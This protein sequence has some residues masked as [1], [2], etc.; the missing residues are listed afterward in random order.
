MTWILLSIALLTY[1]QDVNMQIA[2]SKDTL[3][4]NDV[5]GMETDFITPDGFLVDLG[6]AKDVELRNFQ[7]NQWDQGESSGPIQGF[8]PG[9]SNLGLTTGKTEEDRWWLSQNDVRREQI[10]DYE[11]SR[12]NRKSINM[13]KQK[14]SQKVSISRKIVKSNKQ[15]KFQNNINRKDDKR[16]T[17]LKATAVGLLGLMLLG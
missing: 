13:S 7:L 11:K 4:K 15:T 12:N 1:L 2:Q 16:N 14:E 9:H 3:F 17:A 10:K 8:H 5:G 6:K